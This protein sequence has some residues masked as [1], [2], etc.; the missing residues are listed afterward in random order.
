MGAGRRW[1]DG[2][3][4]G[5]DVPQA[6][7]Y[8]GLSLLGLNRFSDAT[9]ELT[10]FCKETPAGVQSMLQ[11]AERSLQT[12]QPDPARVFLRVVLAVDPS[13]RERYPQLAEMLRRAGL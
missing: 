9:A 8:Y 5:V 6:R 2:I 3:D 1:R 10:E 7:L 12:D 11:Y 4:G 13:A